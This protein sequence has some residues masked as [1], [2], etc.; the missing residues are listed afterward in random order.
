V[1]SELR[2][3]GESLQAGD[4]A[5]KV[6]TDTLLSNALMIADVSKE[7]KSNMMNFLTSEQIEAM[8]NEAK[9]DV[10]KDGVDDE[11]KKSYAKAMGYEYINGK[12]YVGQGAD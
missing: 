8:T 5:V 1:Y 9:A 3:Y 10:A 4:A 6:F 11:E 2:D 7:Q 12:F